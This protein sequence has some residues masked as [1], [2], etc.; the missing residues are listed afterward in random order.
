MELLGCAYIIL[1]ILLMINILRTIRKN[2]FNSA[3]FMRIGIVLYYVL[4]FVNLCFGSVTGYRSRYGEVDPTVWGYLM[5]LLFLCGIEFGRKIKIINSNN[6][7]KSDSSTYYV[8]NE[9]ATVI[10]LSVGVAIFSLITFILYC[11][12]YG[13]I[14]FVFRNIAN[15]RSSV[16]V[17]SNSK[18]EFLEKLYGCVILSPILLL[19][20]CMYKDISPE[21]QIKKGWFLIAFLLALVIR[22]SSGSRSTILTY[23]MMFLL[24][25]A[26]S[27]SDI[28]FKKTKKKKAWII[29]GGIV[30][31]FAVIV[32]RPLLNALGTVSEVGFSTAMSN[33]GSQLFSDNGS[34]YS[35]YSFK[36]TFQGLL[37]SFEHYAVSLETSIKYVH[38]GQHKMNFFMEFMVMLQ[39]VIPSSLLGI[40]KMHDVT[41]YNSGYIVGK[42]NYAQIPPGIIASAYYSGSFIW[43]LFYGLL[44]GYI[45]RR[46]DLFYKKM[47][48][49]VGFAPSLYISILFIYFFFAI[50]G[51]FASQFG[52]NFTFFICLFIIHSHFRVHGNND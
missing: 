31:V 4:P 43:V 29:V 19:P 50:S 46:I 32:Y 34:K 36:D 38:S 30:F 44:F 35:L 48:D 3:L 42:F 12:L 49:N 18:Y 39:S 51:D 20:Y 11:A 33:L 14:G 10:K 52:K 41:F 26:I 16:I 21:R 7:I 17:S 40:T 28:I 25:G 47:K 5:V 37:R 27:K 2:E 6:Q 8:A 23:L 22:V 13:G 9:R 1:G 15:I 24:S 45:G